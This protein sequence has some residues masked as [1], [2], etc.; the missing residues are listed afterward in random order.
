MPEYFEL[1]KLPSVKVRTQYIRNSELDWP[2]RQ[3][4]RPANS[5]SV[6]YDPMRNG[7]GNLRHL[8]PS[9]YGL[10]E[11]WCAGLCF[12]HHWTLAGCQVAKAGQVCLWNHGRPSK[13]WCA[14][15]MERGLCHP[16]IIGWILQCNDAHAPAYNA[17]RD[18]S[19]F[20]PLTD[21]NGK[22]VSRKL[23]P[24][25]A[26]AIRPGRNTTRTRDNPASRRLAT[27]SPWSASVSS[28]NAL[29]P[30]ISPAAS[31]P[32]LQGA[33]CPGLRKL[34]IVK[35]PVTWTDADVEAIVSSHF[36]QYFKGKPA[37]PSESGGVSPEKK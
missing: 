36:E 22:F 9:H 28:S 21:G 16:Q 8:Y 24:L 6:E 13:I 23:P 2:F 10:H 25:P 14:M 29:T 27:S 26:Q 3:Y 17:S 35:T 7:E 20:V 4:A 30:P 34:S 33:D 37:A 31:W 18:L 5:E 12:A 32:P 19:I 1:N 11:H 15:L